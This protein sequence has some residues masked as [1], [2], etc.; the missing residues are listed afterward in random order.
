MSKTYNKLLHAA[1]EW[2]DSPFQ[3]WVAVVVISIGIT[4]GILIVSA[5]LLSLFSIVYNLFT[6]GI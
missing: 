6:A 4:V 5:A 1:V 2:I 3:K